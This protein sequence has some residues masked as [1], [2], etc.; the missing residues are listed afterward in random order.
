MCVVHKGTTVTQELVVR[1]KSE[2]ERKP[3]VFASGKLGSVQNVNNG[4]DEP[5]GR[6]HQGGS[7]SYGKMERVQQKD[8]VIQA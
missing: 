6:S 4:N 2:I 3:V 1:R 7:L 8:L 5:G